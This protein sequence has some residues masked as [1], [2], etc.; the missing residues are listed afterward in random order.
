MAETLSR[1]GV[2]PLT[3]PGS[4]LSHRYEHL[5]RYLP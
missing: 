1:V 2:S 4:L 3:E 5:V